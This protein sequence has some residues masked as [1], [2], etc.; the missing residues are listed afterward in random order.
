MIGVNVRIRNLV[1]MIRILLGYNMRSLI[2]RATSHSQ[3]F[4]NF[5]RI[6]GLFVFQAYL[7]N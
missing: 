4:G 2:D 1:E 3:N 6:L 7:V 5:N